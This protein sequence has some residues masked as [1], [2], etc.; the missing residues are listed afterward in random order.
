MS[1]CRFSVGGAKDCVNFRKKIEMGRL[2]SIADLTY[3]GIFGEY[4]FK[5]NED[6]NNS[7]SSRVEEGELFAPSYTYIQSQHPI[8]DEVE[9]YLSVGLTS[10]LKAS[11]FP[12]K[13]LN[14]IIT[15][16][17]ARTFGLPSLRLES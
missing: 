15:L 11:Q 6:D 1:I 5:T 8:S 14:L 9:H 2:P 3:E 7:P 16:E 4:S 17:Y 12:R 10:K 13:P